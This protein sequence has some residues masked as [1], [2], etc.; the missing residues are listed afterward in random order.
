MSAGYQR[1]YFFDDGLFFECRR[2]GTC[3]TGE[4]GIVYVQADEVARIA[5][6]LDQTV[7]S[8]TAAYLF[9]FRKSFSIREHADGRCRFYQHGCTIYPVRPRQCRSFPFW[10]ENMRSLK[11]WRQVC[12]A[13]PGIGHGRHY[14]KAEILEIINAALADYIKHYGNL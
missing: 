3:C 13:C 9:P 14:S 10:F 11:K 7:A 6:Y 2:C 5:R 4:P 1:S 8:F 12:R